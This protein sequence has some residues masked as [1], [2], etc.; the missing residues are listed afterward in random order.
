[1]RDT[2][3]TIIGALLCVVL[4]GPTVAGIIDATWYFY[5]N[6]TITGV[7]WTEGRVWYAAGMPFLAGTLMSL[8]T[9]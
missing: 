9:I 2:I 8:A 5:S 1:M 7:D 3:G 4:F 6:S